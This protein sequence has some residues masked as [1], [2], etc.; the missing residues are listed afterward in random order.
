MLEDLRRDK[1]SKADLVRLRADFDALQHL[2]GWTLVRFDPT[3]VEMRCGD[4]FVVRLGFEKE[5]TL[6]VVEAPIEM[7]PLSRKMAGSLSAQVTTALL[8]FVNKDVEHKLAKRSVDAKVRLD[9]L[10][11]IKL[12]FSL[13]HS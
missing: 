9:L 6:A 1:R 11:L 4:D 8:T 10:L 13:E 5:G 12:S 3:E 7:V 2:Q